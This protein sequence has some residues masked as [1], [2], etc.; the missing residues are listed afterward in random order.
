[1]L[2]VLTPDNASEEDKKRIKEFQD[3]INESNQKFLDK[4]E[5]NHE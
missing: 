2:L 5:N 4:E 1:M 3:S